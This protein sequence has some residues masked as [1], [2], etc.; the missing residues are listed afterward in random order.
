MDWGLFLVNAQPPGKSSYQ[1]LQDGL[2]YATASE[3]MGFST[4]WVL[5]H[6]FTRFGLVGSPLLYA[7]H[8]LGRTTKLRVGTAIQVITLDHPLRLAE[9]VA[10]LDN[11]SGGRFLFG[12]GRGYFLKDFV[13]FDREQKDTREIA[14]EWLSIMHDAWSAGQCGKDGVHVHVPRVRIYP[15]PITAPHPP[16]YTVGQTDQTIEWAARRAIPLLHPFG[17]PVEHVT[18]ILNQYDEIAAKAGHDPKSVAHVLTMLA[19]VSDD[20]SRVVAAVRKNL[21]W[22]ERTGE[23]ATRLGGLLHRKRFGGPADTINGGAPSISDRVDS[24]LSNSPVGTV[25]ECID[26]IG[27]F[28]EATGVAHIALA[29]EGVGTRPEVID[30]VQ[31]FS[32]DIMPHIAAGGRA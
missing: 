1:V 11:L 14:D 20:R 2:A 4:A 24:Y 21:S 10:L 27:A 19:G 9:Q 7:S 30:N 25:R 6:H 18:R 8:L 32:E 26:R 13:G 15:R 5:E 16:L 22:W 12:F 23:R 17:V 3:T 28:V 31:R 29:I